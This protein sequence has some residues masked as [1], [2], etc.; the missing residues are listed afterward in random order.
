MTEITFTDA[1]NRNLSEKNKLLA[2]KGFHLEL[3][4]VRRGEEI[5]ALYAAYQR[6]SDLPKEFLAVPEKEK[7]YEVLNSDRKWYL[8]VVLDDGTL[9][10]VA[11]VYQCARQEEF[12]Q[13]PLSAVQ[14]DADGV[15]YGISGVLVDQKYK[16]HGMGKAMINNALSSLHYLKSNGVYADC[17]FRNIASFKTLSKMM[18]FIGFTDGRNGGKDEQTLYTTFFYDKPREDNRSS[19]L[20]LDFSGTRNYD[21]AEDVLKNTLKT[22]GAYAAHHVPYEGGYNT[23]YVLDKHVSTKGIELVPSGRNDNDNA[24]QHPY[25][26]SAPRLLGGRYGDMFGGR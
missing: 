7:I 25:T 16:G 3:L 8:G 12:F 21:E 23:I 6:T 17:D 9:V 20:V 22:L 11:K 4:D 5:N 26:I 1:V 14:K 13:P 15:Y 2:H 10:G 19:D 24:K 18:D